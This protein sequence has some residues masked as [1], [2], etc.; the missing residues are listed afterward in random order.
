MK[1]FQKRFIAYLR[2]TVPEWGEIETTPLFAGYT[3]IHN[4][5]PFL[6][7]AQIMALFAYCGGIEGINKAI[8]NRCTFYGGMRLTRIPTISNITAQKLL[9]PTP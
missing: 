3:E 4:R 6:N 5:F 2:K 9:H 1:N 7:S 8:K